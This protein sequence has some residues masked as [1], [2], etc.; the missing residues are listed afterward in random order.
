MFVFLFVL[1]VET[2]E[3]GLRPFKKLSESQ[4]DADKLLG[5]REGIAFFIMQQ[6]LQSSTSTNYSPLLIK[7]FK[8]VY[9]LLD[10]ANKQALMF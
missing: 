4:L 7:R 5:L 10:Q 3:V 9:K 8:T 2:E 1:D 6:L